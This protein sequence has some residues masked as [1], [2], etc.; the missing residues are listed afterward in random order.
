M[1]D[2]NENNIVFSSENIDI[3]LFESLLGNN[4]QGYKYYWLEAIMRLIPSGKTEFSFDEVINE[5]IWEG[6]KTVVFHKLR[7]GHSVNGNAQNFLEH[8]IREL[9]KKTKGQ[10]EKS[11]ISKDKILSVVKKYDDIIRDDKIGLTDYVPYRLIKPFVDKEGKTYID[12]KQYGRFI[13]YL[14]LYNK[15]NKNYFY[16]I[17]N[18]ESPLK[19]KIILNCEWIEFMNTNYAVIMGW[20][21]YNKARFIQARNPGAIGVMDKISPE[22]E[23]RQSLENARCLWKKTVEITGKPLYEIYTGK[24][25]P[26]DCFDLDHFI[27]WSYISNNELWNLIPMSK[28]MNCSKSNKLP[29]KKYIEEMIKYQYYLYELIFNIDNCSK[30]QYISMNQLFNKCK[31]N[32]LNA[33]WAM[34]KL[35]IPGNSFDVFYGVLREN[36]ENI[37]D[38]AKLL[39][40]EIW[41]C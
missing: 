31:K 13:T 40:Y 29:Q 28:K 18:A 17:I 41:E 11:N 36:L 6:W 4:D 20:I 19:K 10:Y 14:E 22:A 38:S 37:Y 25:L 8:A 3:K 15:N 16:N 21:Q 1:Y 32:N 5:M 2:I 24:E 26:L 33:D 12:K 34:S 35:F 30:S 23:N 7:L 27:P 39:E 9:N